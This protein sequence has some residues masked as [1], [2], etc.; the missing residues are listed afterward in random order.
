MLATKDNKN[1]LL[2]GFQS[3][4]GTS[5]IVN[6]L[7]NMPSPNILAHSRH[8]RISLVRLK[9]SQ[10][11]ALKYWLTLSTYSRQTLAR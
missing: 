9:T 3:L 4:F 1:R 11:P 8:H 5:Y 2:F 7:F 6:I 10:D